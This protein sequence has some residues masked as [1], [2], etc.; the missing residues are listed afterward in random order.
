[1][2]VFVVSDNSYLIL[3]FASLFHKDTE[4]ITFKPGDLNFKVFK[5]ND[6]I[7]IDCTSNVDF[8]PL[9]QYVKLCKAR[10]YFLLKHEANIAEKIMSNIINTRIGLEEIISSIII[11]FDINPMIPEKELKLT[12]KEGLIIKMV[13]KG[14]SENEISWFFTIKVKTVRYHINMVIK[15]IGVNSIADLYRFRYIIYNNFFI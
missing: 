13:L 8:T 2:S 6:I 12:K 9:F 4:V 10:V 3:G 15:K 5:E 14:Y 1:M 7:F 11:H